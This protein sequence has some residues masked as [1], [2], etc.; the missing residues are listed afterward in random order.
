[1]ANHFFAQR[2]LNILNQRVLVDDQHVFVR[3]EWELD[4][5]WSE[6]AEF[7]EQFA[8]TLNIAEA[9]ISVRFGNHSQTI[10][11]FVSQQSHALIEVLNQLQ[12]REFS[13]LE[14]QFIV[15]NAEAVRGIADSYGVPFFFIDDGIEALALEKRQLEIV[16]R[17]KPNY[18]G[19]AQYNRTLSADFINKAGCEIID[20]RHELQVS[21]TSADP[22]REAYRRGIKMV[23]ATSRFVSGQLHKGPII[24]Q[25]AIRLAP[26]SSAQEIG[27]L[28]RA[29]ESQ[30]FLQ[31]IS[32]A[33]EHKVMVHD[34]R[35]IVFD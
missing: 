32:K 18:L 25:D 12:A 1:M 31:A 35:T 20:V 8:S 29:I 6:E 23:G 11:L 30:V 5:S 4:Q 19:L 28:S 10:G 14:C 15:A 7:I 22:Y 16:H 27:Q 9:K 17:Y 33:V 3:C 34:N 24:T 21:S 13:D 26:G 2:E